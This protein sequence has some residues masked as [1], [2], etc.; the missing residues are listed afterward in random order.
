M[1]TYTGYPYS[2]GSIHITS[3]TDVLTGYSF[4]TGFLAHPSDLKIQLWG[5]KM[6]REIVRRL[7]FY[8]GDVALGHPEFAAGSA[9]ALVLP[10]SDGDIEGKMAA[11]EDINYSKEDDLAIEDWIRGNL[12]TTWHCLGTCAMRARD[13]G[14]VVDRHLNVYG[15]AG[16]KV[17]DLS[18][19]PEN[20]GANTA[21]TA[22]A[23]GEKAAMIIA[24]ELGVSV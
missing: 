14:G 4:D 23:V 1:G 18:M 3:T 21:N 20:V 2:R 12:A 10:S 11:V 6:Q 7:P 9:A 13:A 16:L 19:V 24:G 8:D 15:T 17:A 22:M 5:Y